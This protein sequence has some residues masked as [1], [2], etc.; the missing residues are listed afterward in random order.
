M[1]T[2]WSVLDDLVEAD[3]GA[4]PPLRARRAVAPGGRRQRHH[5]LVVAAAAE[6]AA[7]GGGGPRPPRRGRAPAGRAGLTAVGIVPARAPV[8]R[9]PRG[10]V[11]RRSPPASRPRSSAAGCGS[12]R[13]S[14]RP[15]PPRRRS[16]CACGPALAR[17]RRRG[18]ACCRCGPT[19]RPTRCPTTTRRRSSGGCAST[20]RCASTARSG[21]GTTPDAAPAARARPP[22]RDP[23]VGEGARVVALALVPVP[24][25]H[26]ALPAAAPPRAASRAPPR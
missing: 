15:R 1:V 3:R 19:S 5:R 25:R 17:A 2:G 8:D 21:C 6:G 18:R 14:S 20:I 11:R 26:R 7:H 9:H 12:R 4:R 22:G 16:R 13:P 10:R 24:A 23:R